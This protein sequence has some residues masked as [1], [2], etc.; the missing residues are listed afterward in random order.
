MKIEIKGKNVAK[1]LQKNPNS[2]PGNGLF[3]E[4]LHE[5]IAICKTEDNKVS[6]YFEDKGHSFEF[7]DV[8][9]DYKG[10]VHS[11]LLYK[12]PSLFT[13]NIISKDKY[14][15]EVISY[16][17]ST[18]KD[19][20][21]NPVNI[22]IEGVLI[23]STY[24]NLLCKYY[25]VEFEEVYNKIYTLTINKST[26]FEAMQILLIFGAI[27]SSRDNQVYFDEKEFE[28]YAQCVLNVNSPYFIKYIYLLMLPIQKKSNVINMFNKDNETYFGFSTQD[29]R[30]NLIESKV[31]K[32][33][34]SNNE[35]TV[36]DYG[37]GEMSYGKKL[38]KLFNKQDNKR[39]KYYAYDIDE[40]MYDNF[41]KL[42]SFSKNTECIQFTEEHKNTKF[43]LV[44]LNEVIE[45]NT[46]EEG[47]KLV[48]DLLYSLDFK[49]MI[50]TTP[51]VSFN[52]NYMM[53]GE[54][55][56]HPDHK[57]EYTYEGFE[58]NINSIIN[59]S[60]TKG[61]D[62]KYIKLGDNING[63]TPTTAAIITKS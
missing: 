12:L 63:E 6:F 36:L 30:L 52:D 31:K 26:L 32:L 42:N 17:D 53:D 51:N 49:T 39:L 15:N 35:L 1:L 50:I 11:S 46:E 29:T 56:R 48:K 55:F 23:E 27:L 58:Y 44:I 59:N 33:L 9:I 18:I 40:S 22:I 47:L 25:N 14:E 20:D 62:V 37:C 54:V 3:L 24:V 60:V 61:F 13:R 21:L 28:K 34:I 7:N 5:G 57:L 8:Q 45:H 38:I 41:N 2:V 19:L 4:K 10:L 43:N 16:L